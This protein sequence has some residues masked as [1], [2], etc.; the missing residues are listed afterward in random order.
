MEINRLNY[1]AFFLDYTEGLLSRAQEKELKE[2]LAANPGLA[3]ELDNYEP[4]HLEQEKIIFQG[5]AGIKKNEDEL[6]PVTQLIALMEGD[7]SAMGAIEVKKKIES[8]DYLK[9]QSELLQKT[10]LVPDFNIHFPYKNKLK[11]R[12][13]II[14]LWRYAAVAAVLIIG[15]TIAFRNNPAEKQN[16]N[17]AKQNTPVPSIIPSVNSNNIITKRS[18]VA[19]EK[20][21]IPQPSAGKIQQSEKK[22]G[23]RIQ[24]QVTLVSPLT[25]NEIASPEDLLTRHREMNL[26]SEP[27]FASLGA[28]NYK[29]VFN[30]DEWK[31]LHN[32][33][34]AGKS[35]WTQQLARE[36]INRL[37]ELTGVKVQ[38]Q[39][40]AFAF[41]I[42]KFEVRHVSG[43]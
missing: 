4:A 35:S 43:K 31:E 5:K 24:E 38:N 12:S 11:R 21:L 9:K 20:K 18:D 16:K 40:N 19:S 33:S 30:E 7:L 10:K 8:E 22:P 6:T 28:F 39:Q 23:E 17:I 34:I 29:D 41:S 13:R 37:G 27:V 26:N 42:G 3:A 32:M 25:V 36:G 2:F 14:Y 1:E 15:L